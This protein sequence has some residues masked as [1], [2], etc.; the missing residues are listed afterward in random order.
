MSIALPP[1][2]HN[3]LWRLFAGR[4]QT[5]ACTDRVS[6][7]LK[8][9]AVRQNQGPGSGTFPLFDAF[10]KQSGLTDRN[11]AADARTVSPPA[12]GGAN[13]MSYDDWEK[14]WTPAMQSLGDVMVS[15]ADL[16][17]WVKRT[18][19]PATQKMYA[20]T[21]LTPAQFNDY[22]KYWITSRMAGDAGTGG[23]PGDWITSFANMAKPDFSPGSAY[24]SPYIY[25]ETNPQTANG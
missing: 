2:A 6:H 4:L 1:G 21:E 3:S 18:G 8:N 12:P 23:I 20:D 10:M 9:E 19:G 15:F 25:Y 7:G 24:K 13:I 16:D 17:P 22:Y 14:R 11:T 5:P